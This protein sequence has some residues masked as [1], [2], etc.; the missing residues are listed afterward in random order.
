MLYPACLPALVFSGGNHVEEGI[1]VDCIFRH[2]GAFDWPAICTRS[3]SHA[4]ARPEK[5]QDRIYGSQMMTQQERDEYRSK[6][7]AAKT[8]EER[9]RIRKEH[10]ERM[11]VLAKEQGVTIPDEPPVRGGGMMGPG[12]GMG[13]GSGG[14][15]SGG[16][17]NR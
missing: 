13:P 7:R 8:F 14:M 15:G 16:S 9:E 11:K 4:A 12:G 3:G 10:Q 17:R 2:L 1:D 6:M 5:N